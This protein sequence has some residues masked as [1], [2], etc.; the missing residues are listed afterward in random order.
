MIGIPAS[1]KDFFAQ[2]DTRAGFNYSLV[3]EN[4]VLFGALANSIKHPSLMPGVYWYKYNEVI[5]FIDG[6]GFRVEPH[7]SGD[8]YIIT[9]I[10]KEPSRVYTDE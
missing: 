8:G 6:N 7:V 9:P 2:L 4:E 3:K 1:L 10:R 5:D